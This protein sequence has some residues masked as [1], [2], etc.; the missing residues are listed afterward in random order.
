MQ[1]DDGPVDLIAPLSKL[2][3]ELLRIVGRIKLA[4]QLA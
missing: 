4:R 1:F 3:E 2:G